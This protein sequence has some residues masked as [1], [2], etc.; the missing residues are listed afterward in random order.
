MESA[1]PIW[2]SRSFVHQATSSLVPSAAPN[3][4]SSGRGT[5]GGRRSGLRG[6]GRLGRRLGR[7]RRDVFL[8]VVLDGLFVRGEQDGGVALGVEHL[9]RAA[10]G[11]L[12]GRQLQRRRGEVGHRRGRADADLDDALDA[13]TT[14]CGRG[15]HQVLGLDPAHRA[16]ELPGQELDQD[17]AAQ[18]TRPLRPG[19]E[20][21]QHGVER[22]VRGQLGDL[23]EEVA[24]EAER[25][26]HEVGH[27]APDQRGRV[28]RGREQLLQAG[29]EVG[30]AAA[31]DARVE[32]HVDARHEDEGGLAAERGT[33]LLD[34]GLER[35]ESGDRAGDG[36]LRALEV[37]VGD[38]EELAGVVGDPV[39]EGADVLV[40]DAELRRT[41]GREPVVAAAFVVTRHQGVHDGAA[42]EHDL[43]DGF[44]R[45]DAGHR[46]ERVVLAHGVTGEH[47]AL[48]EG[49]GLAQL[50][51]LRRAEHGH[52]DLGELGQEQ[53]AVG[54]TVRRPGGDDLGRV[55]ADDGEDREAECLAG[56]LVGT[57]PDRPRG[58][59]AL[60]AGHA[61]ALVLDA[62]TGEDVRGPRCDQAGGRGHDDLAVHAAGDVDDLVAGVEADAVGA[63]VDAR[64]GTHRGS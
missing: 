27:V 19:V 38:L 63:D 28:D 30:H 58:L 21:G 51:H 52:G 10:Q 47:G 12:D 40:G 56:V 6:F 62:L 54:V 14:V 20:V 42:L 1:A 57:V 55:V 31:Q 24:V 33:A 61:H 48:D 8:L 3:V 44:Q 9:D 23:G 17:E 16:G 43:D 41:D 49:A 39:D 15:E 26:R 7:A 13:E 46:G 59:A 34:L 5:G 25:L 53:H 29:P 18:L 60:V 64:A 11:P 35:L 22:P 45:D 36:V 37:E 32:R 2:S 4:R 50:G